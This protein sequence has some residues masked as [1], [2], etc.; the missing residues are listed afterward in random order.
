MDIGHMDAGR[1][2]DLLAGIG[3]N[4]S[5]HRR[6]AGVTQANLALGIGKSV[7]WVAGV[8]QGRIH[9]DRLTDLVRISSVVGCRVEDLI[10]RPVDTLTP[11]ASRKAEAV[12]AVREVLMRSAVP[13]PSNTPAPG[14]DEV[15]DRVAEAWTVWH[16][17]PCPAR[18]MRFLSCR[19]GYAANR[20]PESR[21][22]P[23]GRGAGAV[24]EMGASGDLVAGAGDAV[25]D[26]G[27]RGRGVVEQRG[28]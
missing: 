28:S 17:S 25:E 24:E 5:T 23:L 20:T 12:A 27:G 4:I 9:A 6:A 14:L 21:A 22:G 10:G 8:E 7:Q 1:E 16:G 18:E 19:L 13:A 15:G 3:A 26:R 2:P 11:G